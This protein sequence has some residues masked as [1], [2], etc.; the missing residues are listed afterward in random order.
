MSG[1]APTWLSTLA[2][3]ERLATDE[4]EVTLSPVWCRKAAGW[5]ECI[6]AFAL[7]L[8]IANDHVLKGAGFLP[9]SVT[10]KLSDFAGLVVAPVLVAVLVALA[11][12]R[13][14]RTRAACFAAVVM[15]FAAIKL[16]IDAAVAL[17]SVLAL[18]G[19]R[20]RVWSDP[21]DLVALGVLPFVWRV[22]ES[23]ERHVAEKARLVHVLGAMLGGIACVATSAPLPDKYRTS[24]YLVSMARTKV[25]VDVSRVTIALDCSALDAS[26]TAL[27]A[28]DFEPTFCSSLFPSD[29]LPLDRDFAR[30]S[31]D[32]FDSPVEEEPPCDAVLIG[33]RGLDPTIV[34][35]RKG[36]SKTPQN[37]SVGSEL[38]P[39]AVY[40]EPAGSS[41]YVAASGVMHVRTLDGPVPDVACSSLDEPE[42][43]P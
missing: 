42:G 5:A 34:Y 37:R 14:P 2:G 8:L 12:I 7:A 35:W 3:A 17:Q 29:V 10:G 43:L 20:S 26:I 9:G 1:W 6:W 21:T 18:A 15:P 36:A 23:L 30:G 32:D 27:G 13:G 16:S 19:V 39:S 38:D 4:N 31:G 28:N 41:F 22:A 33:A 24:A 11:G 40:L 25:T